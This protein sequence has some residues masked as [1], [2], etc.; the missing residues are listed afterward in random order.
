MVRVLARRRRWRCSVR[1][2]SRRFF[3]HA[4]LG[5]VARAERLYIPASACTSPR[6]PASY[7]PSFPAQIQLAH[8]PRRLSGPFFMPPA[9]AHGLHRGPFFVSDPRYEC[10]GRARERL[11]PRA[12]CVRSMEAV[13]TGQRP[14]PAYPRRATGVC[15]AILAP[16]LR[17]WH[18]Y[19]ARV[20]TP[21][22][23]ALQRRIRAYLTP[24]VSAYIAARYP[25]TPAIA[26]KLW[27]R[28]TDVP[29]QVCAIARSREPES[30]I[31]R[32]KVVKVP[33]PGR[34]FLP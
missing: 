14:R 30:H 1:R 24:T 28:K 29:Q 21:V 22:I 10:H 34:I 8:W 16:F 26:P 6:Y 9:T 2:C 20:F 3:N 17:P 32:A 23:W 5:G 31:V 7:R 11:Y 15:R 19:T 27:A 13:H 4:Q 18:C 12:V 25:K 33:A